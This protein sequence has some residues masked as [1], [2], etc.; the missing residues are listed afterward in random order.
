MNLTSIHEDVDL[1]PGLS[2][3][4]AMSSGVS[5]RQG[6]DPAFLCL[7]LWPAAAAPIQP[8]AWEPPIAAGAAPKRPKEK[9]KNS[10]PFGVAVIWRCCD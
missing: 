10:Q 4:V 9:R 5:H 1:I 8:L 3:G 6:L 2:L 7:W